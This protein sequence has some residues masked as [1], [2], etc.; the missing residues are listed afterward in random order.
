MTTIAAAPRRTRPLRTAAD[1]PG[2]S[3][4]LG[5]NSLVKGALSSHS[6]YWFTRH[7]IRRPR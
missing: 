7:V 1:T 2:E 6:E 3:R 4:G 5:T